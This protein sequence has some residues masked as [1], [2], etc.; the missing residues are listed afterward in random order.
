[1]KYICGVFLYTFGAANI[2]KH[3][4]QRVEWQRIYFGELN[5]GQRSS[6]GA[7]M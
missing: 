5:R 7:S 6:Q 1:M 4:L 2:L 3:L